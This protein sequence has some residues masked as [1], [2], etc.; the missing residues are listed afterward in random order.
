VALL[1]PQWR[2]PRISPLSLQFAFPVVARYSEASASRLKSRRAAAST[3]PEQR[4][5]AEVKPRRAKRLIPLPI[6]ATN[7]KNTSK[8]PCQAPKPLNSNKTNQI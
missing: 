6:P 8:N 1:P 7:L 2:D 4:R 5:G 3:Q